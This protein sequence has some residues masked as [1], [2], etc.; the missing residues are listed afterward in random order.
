MILNK[1]IYQYVARFGLLNGL[2]LFLTV[3]AS[4]SKGTISFHIPKLEHKVYIRRRSTDFLVFEEIFIDEIYKQ[5]GTIDPRYIIDAGA[6]IGL[7]ALYFQRTF[8]GA[9][10]ISVEP[11]SDNFDLLKLNTSGYQNI[12]CYHNGLWDKKSNLKITNTAEGAWAFMVEETDEEGDICAISINDILRELPTDQ[13]DVLKMDIEGSEK[14]VFETSTEWI[15]LTK[16]IIV[17][18]H[19]N[20]RKGATDAVLRALRGFSFSKVCCTYHFD[21]N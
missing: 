4:R 7:A 19:E 20:K 12:T 9:K 6:N 2:K 8:P 15:N 1:R 18:V 13:I 14:E 17:E 21:R 11:V 10:I 16:R 5:P 3:R